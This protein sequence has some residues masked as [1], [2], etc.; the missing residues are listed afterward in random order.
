MGDGEVTVDKIGGGQNGGQRE[1]K[2][3]CEVQWRK[4][5]GMRG[6]EVEG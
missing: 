5:G 2:G 6:N 1:E 4:E 3:M